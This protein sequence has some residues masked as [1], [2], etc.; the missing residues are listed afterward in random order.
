[1]VLRVTAAALDRNATHKPR[2]ESLPVR[3]SVC[4]IKPHEPRPG[5]TMD[6]H[7]N[8]DPRPLFNDI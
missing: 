7:D 6:I 1:M 4:H 8:H 3:R 5:G 2:A